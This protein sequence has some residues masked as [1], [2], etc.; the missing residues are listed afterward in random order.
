MTTELTL[1]A[2]AVMLGVLHIVLASRAASWQRGYRWAASARD[3]AVPPLTGLAGRLDRSLHNFTETFPLFSRGGPR[4]SHCRRD[5]GANALGRG[6]LSWS[7]HGLLA[8]FCSRH[9][10]DPLS[11][12]ERRNLRYRVDPLC[13]VVVTHGKAY[14]APNCAVGLLD[15]ILL[16]S[17]GEFLRIDA[18]ERTALSPQGKLYVSGAMAAA[19]APLDVLRFACLEPGPR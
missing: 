19:P 4:G 18:R 9:L 15:V 17:F 7:P 1:L 5:R 6:P 12:L 8:D 13:P 2:L 16:R 11:R 14:P 10:S 3:V